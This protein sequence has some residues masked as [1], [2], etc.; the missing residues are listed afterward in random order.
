MK[1]EKCG[2][3]APLRDK[4]YSERGTLA[5]GRLRVCDYCFWED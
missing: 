2:E 4:F 5:R 1:C 3:T